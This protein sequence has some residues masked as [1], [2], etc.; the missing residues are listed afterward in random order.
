VLTAEH[1]VI[2][3][4]TRPARPDA[5]EFDGRTIMD[6]D[7]VLALEHVPRSMVIVGAG[8]IGMEVRQT[9]ELAA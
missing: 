7:N 6:S 8:V 4:G 5:V 2:A 9:L 1:I 3:C